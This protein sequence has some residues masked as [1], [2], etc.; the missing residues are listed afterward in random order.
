VLG[1]D[2][3]RAFNLRVDEDRTRVYHQV[4]F[5]FGPPAY[6]AAGVNEETV[7]RRQAILEW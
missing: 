5:R 7:R 4:T 2:F 3:A 1:A 6:G